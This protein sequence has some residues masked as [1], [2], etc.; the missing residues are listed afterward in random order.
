MKARRL[1]LW[2]QTLTRD[3]RNQSGYV[4]SLNQLKTINLQL[5][6]EVVLGVCGPKVQSTYHSFTVRLMY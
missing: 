4:G 2:Q 6:E 3:L 5:L 1:I